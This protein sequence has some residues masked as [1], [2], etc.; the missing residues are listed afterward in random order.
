MFRS[1]AACLLFLVNFASAQTPPELQARIKAATAERRYSDAISDLVLMDRT[2]PHVFRWN[3]YDYLLGRLYERNGQRGEAMK[4]YLSVRNR[5]SI[6][7]A[8][9]LFHSAA[10]ARSSGN[11][12]LERSFLNELEL[13]SENALLIDPARNRAARSLFESNDIPGATSAFKALSSGAASSTGQTPESQVN[14]ENRLYLAR[15]LLLGGD[16]AAAR[17]GFNALIQSLAN[18]AQPD[19]IALAAVRELDRLDA[20]VVLTE[21]EHVRRAAIY[22]FNRDFGAARRHFALVISEYTTSGSVADAL[23]QTGRGYTQETNFSEATKWY[24]R[25][26]EQFPQHPA[27]KDSLL[28][29]AS[30]Y[31]RVGRFRESIKR[32]HEY[33]DRY[34]NDERVDRAYLNIIDVL[35]DEGEEAEALKWAGEVQVALKGKLG[36]TQALFAEVRMHISRGNWSSALAGLTRLQSM[37]DLGGS[38]VPGGTSKA[39]LAFLRGFVLE[40]IR[41]FPEAIGTYLGIPDGRSEYFGAR[42]SERLLAMARD[43]SAKGAVRNKLDQ[44]TAALGSKDQDL[45]RRTLQSAVRLAAEPD[46]RGRIIALLNRAYA[47]LPAYKKLPENK[48]VEAGRKELRLKE[49]A[50]DARTAD[51]TIADELLFLGLSDEAAPEYDAVVQDGSPDQQFTKAVL[52]ERGDRPYKALAFLESQFRGVPADYQ[53]ELIPRGQLELLYPTPFREAFAAHTAPRGIDPRFLLSLVRQESRYQPDVKSYAA[54]RGL[55]Q[56]ISTTADKIASELGRADFEQ[57]ELYDPWTAVLFGSQYAS[58]LFKLFPNQPEAVAASY[59][60]GEDNMRRWLR[61]A[62]SQNPDRYVSEIAFAQSKDYVYRVMANYRVY[63]M[64]YDERLTPLS[65]R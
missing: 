22:Q 64:L 20:S 51:R 26:L 34:P 7:A 56:F 40:Q 2:Y 36:E 8:Y 31:A 60:G 61:R 15:C 10:I 52:Y 23:Y 21:A 27:A 12:V 37:N 48:L 57:D 6:L 50:A 25:V 14:R 65:V 28:Q 9:A 16:A 59:N 49:H 29:A 11:L 41:N 4:Y 39:E 53:T 18:P 1:V 30:A 24:E 43:E 45:E 55:M 62:K 63:K 42:A 3:N 5:D 35:R 54:A 32:Y 44:L 19:D 38:N 33:I 17:D 47:N 46:E 58:D 13:S